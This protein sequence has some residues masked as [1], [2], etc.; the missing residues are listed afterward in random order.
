MKKDY[1][2][3]KAVKL[4]FDYAENVTASQAPGHKYQKYTDGYYAC[5]ETPTGIW[6]KGDLP[7]D[8]AGCEWD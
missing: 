2:A 8:F 6:V 7:P 1:T 3:P 4:E 5:R